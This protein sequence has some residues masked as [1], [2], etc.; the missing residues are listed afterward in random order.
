AG[1]GGGEIYSGGG[2]NKYIIPGK[3]TSP[4]TIYL[5]EDSDKNEIILP[6]N[7]LEQINLTGTYLHLKDGENIQ[8]K[9]NVSGENVGAEWIRIYTNGDASN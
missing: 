8:L 7:N 9:R 3:M 1:Y 2:S 4:L 5:E 6:E